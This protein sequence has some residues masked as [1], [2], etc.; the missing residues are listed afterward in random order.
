[1]KPGWKVRSSSLPQVRGGCVAASSTGPTAAVRTTTG[2]C[3][4]RAR[5]PA[6]TRADPEGDNGEQTQREQ[7]CPPL[8]RSSGACH[9]GPLLRS[10]KVISGEGAAMRL[11]DHR[12][13]DLPVR[14][15]RRLG[16][17][18][19]STRVEAPSATRAAWLV[20]MAVEKVRALVATGLNGQGRCW[21][22]RRIGTEAL[23]PALV[24]ARPA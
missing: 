20:T 3:C 16:Q 7:A 15:G 1:L 22:P 23:N 9:V 13:D 17:P 6:G 8:R 4:V 5:P 18:A 10:V 12:N 11:S 19:A 21:A 24:T 14:A 2:G